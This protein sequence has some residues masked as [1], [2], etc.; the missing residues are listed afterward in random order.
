MTELGVVVT[1]T[2]FGPKT[3]FDSLN[4]SSRLP[5]KSENVVVMDD[6]LGVVG[7][8]AEDVALEL[9]GGIQSN[10]YAKSA[11]YTADDVLPDAAVDKLFKYID[12]TDKGTPIWFLIWDLEGGKI[13]DYAPDATAYGH[14]DALFYHQAYAVNLFGRVDD[15]IRNFLTG[16]NQI[17]TDGVGRELGAYAGYVD[18]ALGDKG[19][20]MYWGDNLDRLQTI[21]KAVDP[22]EVFWNPQSVRPAA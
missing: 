1:G 14:R 11:A 12:S 5:N 17:V 20:G 6:W 8:W 18:R 22:K 2:Y 4:I 3:E 9:V 19:P 7:H 16:L 15:K 13:N 21:K 10:F